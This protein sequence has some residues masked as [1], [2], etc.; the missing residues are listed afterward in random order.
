[1]QPDL[2]STPFTVSQLTF[3]IRR[4]LEDNPE[5]QDVW[6]SGEVSNLSRPASGHIYFTLKDKNASLKCVMWKTDAART[7]PNLQEGAAV[8]VH[9][10]IAVYEPQGQYQLIA[11]LIQ[12]KG[13]GALFQEFLRLKSML[14]A[15]GLFSSDRKREIPAFPQTIGI[16]T[17]ATGAAL[18]DMLNT[19]RRR[20]PLARVILAPSPVQGVEAPPALVAALRS[21]NKQN[22][23][24][25]L[26]ARGGGSIEDLWAFN[27]E[28]VVREVANSK[29]PIISGV[30]HE[31]DFTLCDFAA[32]LRAPT[33]TAAAELATQTTLD[34]LRFQL[35]NAQARLTGLI[36]N[37]LTDHQTSI[38]ALGSR[39]KF[40]SPERRIQADYQ[41]LDELSRRAFSAL[42]HRI[43][44]HSARVDGIS[45]RLQ[46]LNPEGILARG[47]AI[48]TRKQ[49]G[50]VVSTVS[51]A[52]GDL[53][54]RVSDG[55]F[56]ARRNS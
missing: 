45:S 18:R 47:Y 41:H 11:N 14:E 16:V 33:P 50:K 4:L 46:A 25:I 21:L 49:D 42:T 1:M 2:F 22:P 7:R 27:D 20:Q 56:E 29:A 54:V 44:L 32:D 36:S 13:E 8:E 39:L 3:R 6:V 17:S 43:Q 5:F 28:G 34:D 15:E 52:Q 19:I 55:D 51:Q 30:G 38:S 40:V 10:K 31:T 12:A 9:G 48:I 24:V 26:V 37:R 53:T 35:V 23:D